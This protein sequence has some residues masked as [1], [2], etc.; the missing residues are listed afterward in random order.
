MSPMPLLVHYFENGHFI[1]NVR[2]YNCMFVMTS[3]GPR[4]DESI[5]KSCAPYVFKVYGQ[6]S[7]WIGSFYP[8]SDIHL[9]TENEISNRLHSFRGEDDVLLSSKVV[10][11]LSHVLNTHKT[12]KDMAESMN[13]DS[14][15]VRLFSFVPDRIYGPLVPGSLRCIISGDD[16]SRAIYDIVVFSKSGFAQRI[17]ECHHIY[18]LILHVRRLFHQ[19]LVDAYTCID[20]SSHDYFEHHQERLCNEYISSVCDALSKGDTDSRD[21][22]KRIFLPSSFFG[23]PMY[24]YKHYQDALPMCRCNARRSGLVNLEIIGVEN[25][26]SKKDYLE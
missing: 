23:G 8:E 16:V 5:N 15:G 11:S 12:T 20:Q 9:D 26:F 21:I 25:D 17:H 3:F 13:L 1:R 7:H 6:I 24:M 4:V 22:G 14:Y 18:S 10:E 2:A 19:F